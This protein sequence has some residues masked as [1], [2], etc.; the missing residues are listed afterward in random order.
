MFVLE[1]RNLDGGSKRGGTRLDTNN[2]MHI[3]ILE[4][5]ELKLVRLGDDN[6]MMTKRNENHSGMSDMLLS[7]THDIVFF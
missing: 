3:D 7:V 6:T 1:K 2:N 4:K 5:V